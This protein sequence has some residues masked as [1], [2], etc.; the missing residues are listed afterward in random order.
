MLFRVIVVRNPANPGSGWKVSI[1]AGDEAP[2]AAYA[3]GETAERFPLP[4]GGEA[5]LPP[6]I[7]GAEISDRFTN[8]M[9]QAGGAGAV[10]IFGAYL[11]NCLLAGAWPAILTQASGKPFELALTWE[12]AEADLNRLPWEAMH[13]G[14]HPGDFRGF[15]A[16]QPV[17]ITR[18]VSG[19]T[20]T[21]SGGKLP[22]P[23]RVLFVIG[24]PLSDPVIRPG[25]E[26][27]GLL[28]SLDDDGL[29]LNHRLLLDATLDSLKA[30]ITSFHPNIVH[31]VSHGQIEGR[32]ACLEV[33]QK[34]RLQRNSG[35]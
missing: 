19:S 25:A 31:I 9:S 34:S 29:V 22:S 17:T 32:P 8:L 20:A 33:P 24:V 26:Y 21:L 23:P 4:E 1:A 27:L 11:F 12:A 13:T 16:G 2:F 7:T 5:A 3:M 30:A 15:L 10:E 35:D 18:R 14:A 28:H 6:G